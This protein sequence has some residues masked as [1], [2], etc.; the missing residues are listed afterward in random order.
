MCCEQFEFAHFA[1]S[2]KNYTKSIKALGG[3]GKI[4]TVIEI[5]TTRCHNDVEI[6]T[7][8]KDDYHSF[9][10]STLTRIK[11]AIYFFSSD[12]H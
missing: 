6:E 2:A 12:L 1:L 5:L 9:Y 10:Y 8:V 7:V 11:H 3:W 4:G